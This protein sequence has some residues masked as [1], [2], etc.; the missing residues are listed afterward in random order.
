MKSFFLGTLIAVTAVLV[1][2]FI[3]PLIPY[4][5]NQYIYLL[6]LL[7]VFAGLL[8]V[9]TGSKGKKWKEFRKQ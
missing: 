8:L 3:G 1:V 9:I 4:A 2:I 6:L 7:I 5:G